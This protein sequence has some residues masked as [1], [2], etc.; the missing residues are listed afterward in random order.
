MDG[1]FDIAGYRMSLAQE[2]L[3]GSTAKGRIM[4]IWQCGGAE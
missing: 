4:V 2:L 1:F 3:F